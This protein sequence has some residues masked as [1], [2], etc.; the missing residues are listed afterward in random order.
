MALPPLLFTNP[1]HFTIDWTTITH[2]A[3]SLPSKECNDA[4][5][6]ILGDS[7]TKGT[8]SVTMTILSLP[9]PNRVGSVRMGLVQSTAAVPQLGEFIGWDVK[10]SLSLNSSTGN[11]SRNTPSTG[12]S[13]QFEFCHSQLKEGDCVRM[14]VD[15]DSKP[16]T[17]QFFVNGK[18]GFSFVSG[19]PP[20]VRIGFA[21]SGQ[22]TF[23]RI[24]R[25]ARQERPTPITPEMREITW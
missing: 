24:D 16:R 23:C 20:S 1:A 11:L 3:I 4:S 25:I 21:V 19:L 22:G 15:M 13:P 12:Y 5:S 14:E 9:I 6:V 2:S 7:V 10:D 17:V 18:C 8:V